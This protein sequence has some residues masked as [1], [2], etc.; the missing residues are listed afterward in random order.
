MGG[1]SRDSREGVRFGAGEAGLG[2]SRCM[3]VE[4]GQPA[5][6]SQ[7]QQQ[8]QRRR[9]RGSGGGGKREAEMEWEKKKKVREKTGLCTLTRSSNFSLGLF[10]YLPQA[11]RKERRKEGD[12]SPGYGR[13]SCQRL[14]PLPSKSLDNRCYCFRDG[15]LHEGP[16]DPEE[17]MWVSECVCVCVCVPTYVRRAQIRGGIAGCL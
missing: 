17:S 2:D 6:S 15:S 12:R 13:V 9:R 1:V 14:E 5:A 3:C 16:E 4:A 11:Q 10:L 8:Q 7:Q